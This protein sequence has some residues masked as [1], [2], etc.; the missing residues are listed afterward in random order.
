MICGAYFCLAIM[1][2]GAESFLRFCSFLLS[3][4]SFSADLSRSCA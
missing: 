1:L 3:C 4:F 2:Q